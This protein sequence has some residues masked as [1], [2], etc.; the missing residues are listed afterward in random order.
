VYKEPAENSRRKLSE[1]Y[2]HVSSNGASDGSISNDSQKMEKRKAS[3]T[4]LQKG[5]AESGETPAAKSPRSS[6][7]EVDRAGAADDSLPALEKKQ[8]SPTKLKQPVTV[9]RSELTSAEV[10]SPVLQVVCQTPERSQK[11][12]YKYAEGMLADGDVCRG[13]RASHN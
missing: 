7:E 2:R 1:K 5:R 3:V 9:A 6:D 8:P 11:H 4:P 10:I 12:L 13:T